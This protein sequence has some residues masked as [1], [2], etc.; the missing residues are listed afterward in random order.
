M[1]DP[2]GRL[3]LT[4]A[5]KHL[6]LL[7]DE[8]DNYEWVDP[9]DYRVAEVRLLHDHSSVGVVAEER[10]ADNLLVR[11]DALHALR[12]LS[13]LPEFSRTLAGKV[14]CCYIDPPFNT[15]EAFPHYDDGLEHSVWLTM[16]RD[17]LIQVRDLLALDGSV[18]VHLDD[19][20]AH[21]ARCV[22][23]EVFGPS[24][25]IATVV[26]EKTPGAKG[27]TDI[28]ASHDY[29]VV[30]AKDQE[31]WR[32]TRNL[33]DRTPG[34]AARYANPDDDPRGP[35]RQYADG[36]A[37]SGSERLRYEVVLPSGRSV[38]PPKGSY[39][40]F[41]EE[42]LARARAEGRV[43]FGREGDSLP[44]IKTYLSE[45]KQGVVPRTWWP[46]SEVGSNQEAKRDHL[47]R[48]FPDI[49][50]FATPKPERLLQR[51]LHIATN[52]D[53]LVLDF[54]AGSGTTAA[55][56]HKMRRRWIAVEWRAETVAT[57]ALP[58]LVRVV[59][60]TDPWGVTEACAWQGGSGF[61][62][63]DVAPS[64]YVSVNS[65]VFLAEWA[66]NGALAETTAAQLG[67]AFDP[68]IRPFCGRK[69]RRRLAV[70]DGLVD[71]NVVRLLVGEL[72]PGEHVI[73]AGTS[74]DPAARAELPK[75]S[76]LRKIPDALLQSYQRESR[77]AYLVP[78]PAPTAPIGVSG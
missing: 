20:E 30:Y 54:F 75:G 40:R 59:D 42:T 12:S 68:G 4:W 23:D 14:K 43:W 37:K 5:N 10:A 78:P 3:E 19:N 53:D 8:E 41:T 17:R 48:L 35:W 13:H 21:R 24:N 29:I 76:S 45:V 7:A 71:A 15:G 36:T 62:V 58:R 63:L 27:D 18:W 11:G 74:I 65:L 39:W 73:V 47:R 16:L 25:F 67:F 64:M 66:T 70:V 26:W 72:G 28:S 55:V 60:G 50:P 56:A 22:L 49:E 6:R 34:Q 51:I 61:R 57:F 31:R 44:V 52:E 77:L 33:L 1:A 9:A 69:G 38:R 32:R 46:S 2:E